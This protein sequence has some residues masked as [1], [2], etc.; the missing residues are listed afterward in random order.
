MSSQST[1]NDEYQVA[2]NVFAFT[3]TDVNWVL[4]QEGTELTLIDAG[5]EGDIQDVERSIRSLGRRPEDV[6]AVL[7]THAHA[8]HTGAL[9]HLHDMYGVPLY[10]DAVEVLNA[11]GEHVE[12]GGAVDVARYLYRPQV[13]RWAAHMVKAGALQHTTS[14]GA[15]PFPHE[16]ALDLPGGPVPIA[17]S[18]HTSGHTSYFL[19]SVG[20][21]ITG[22]ALVSAHPTLKDVGPRLLPAGFTHDQHRAI[23]S[24]ESLRVLDADMFVPGHG[25]AWYGRI[26]DSVE[27]ALAHVTHN[28]S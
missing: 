27:Q 20:A 22:D 9:N 15:Q 18:G 8:D 14:P 25:A 3:G 26:S 23:E 28:R 17:T 10:M 21:V 1:N 2:D 11:R 16:G 7:L 4:V 5:W 19:P 6:R 12:T 24:L 13:V